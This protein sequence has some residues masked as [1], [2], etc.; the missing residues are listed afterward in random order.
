MHLR[1][2]LLC[3]LPLA[4]F[5]CASKPQPRTTP[6]AEVAEPPPAPAPRPDPAAELAPVKPPEQTP[7]QTPAETPEAPAAECQG[8]KDCRAKG[9]PSKGMRWTCFEGQCMVE[10]KAKAKKGKKRPK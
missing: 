9:K 8:P 4:L 7:E 6:A 5:A 3:S 10:P 1:H 2:L